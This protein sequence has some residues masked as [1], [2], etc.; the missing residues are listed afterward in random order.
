M[1]MKAE[2]TR[3]SREGGPLLPT[4]AATASP[5]AALISVDTCCHEERTPVTR[6]HS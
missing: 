4:G 6:G 5:P 2:A 1:Y 3:T